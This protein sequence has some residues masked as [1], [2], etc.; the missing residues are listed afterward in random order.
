MGLWKFLLKNKR[1]RKFHFLKYEK[2]FQ[3]VFYVCFASSES[4]LLNF[5]NLRSRKFRFP[6]YENFLILVAESYISQNKRKTFFW[7]NTRTFL[8]VG[9][10]RE[11]FWGLRQESIRSFLIL[12][13]E[14]SVSQNIRKSFLRKYKRV[15]N[16]WAKKFPTDFFNLSVRKFR[17]PKYKKIYF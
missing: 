2:C 3:S 8:R 5:L 10:F 4:S 7:E 16:L 1:A 9:F 6:K 15:F 14:S 13:L 17:F 12:G 11:K